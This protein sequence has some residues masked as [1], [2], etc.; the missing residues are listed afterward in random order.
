MK[1]KIFNVTLI[2]TFI[3]VVAISTLVGIA[4]ANVPVY[5]ENLPTL[6]DNKK[7][8]V[9]DIALSQVDTLEDSETHYTIYAEWYDSEN[10][11][12][13]NWSNIFIQY[14]LHY[15]E[16][17]YLPNDIILEDFINNVD[18]IYYKDTTYTPTEGDLVYL[19]INNDNDVDY[20][21]ILVDSDE[22]GLID[23]VVIGDYNDKVSLIE[24][25]YSLKIENT[26][27]NTFTILGYVNI[28]EELSILSTENNE[29][30]NNDNNEEL[31]DNSNEEENND[32]SNEDDSLLLGAN[33][34]GELT[35]TSNGYTITI[36]YNNG[37]IPD[38]TEL[39]FEIINSLTYSDLL[40]AYI[41]TNNQLIN[42]VII[43][44]YDKDKNVITP[45]EDVE[46]TITW[47]SSYGEY[48]KLI[49]YVTDNSNMT[50]EE[51]ELD[52]LTTTSLTYTTSDLGYIAIYSDEEIAQTPVLSFSYIKKGPNTDT[53]ATD[54]QVLI[55]KIINL[56]S[57]TFQK[58]KVEVGP[59]GYD[60]SGNQIFNF[61]D[62]TNKKA[63]TDYSKC[64]TSSGNCDQLLF[65][66]PSPKTTKSGVVTTYGGDGNYIGKLY[67]N[68]VTTIHGRSV[69]AVITIDK[70]VY[71]STA[72]TSKKDVSFMRFSVGNSK[73]IV[74][75]CVNN[76]Y[77]LTE[78][79][80][81]TSNTPIIQV[82]LTTTFYWS[83]TNYT[84][85]V[86]EKFMGIAY[87]IDQSD[88]KEALTF[89]KNYTGKFYQFYKN[90][91]SS[92][93]DLYT[94]T[95]SGGIMFTPRKDNLDNDDSWIIG[96]IAGIVYNGYT[97][98]FR[99]ADCQT[100][101]YAGYADNNNEPT[102]SITDLE[103][104]TN[105]YIAGEELTYNID[106]SVGTFFDD[107]WITYSKYE[108][109]DYLPD[110]VEF[111]DARI[112]INN[113]EV[114]NLTDKLTND[115][116]T[117]SYDSSKHKLTFTF[118][119]D[120]LSKMSSYNNQSIE[121]QID[122]KIN[123]NSVGDRI[124]NTGIVLINNSTYV[125]NKVS[126]MTAGYALPETGGTNQ[127]ISILMGLIFILGS[128]VGG[129]IYKFKYQG[130]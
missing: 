110:E 67:F 116:G 50:V 41:G 62:L 40:S 15:A 63:G 101:Y 68:G 69:D 28:P 60:S 123:D 78:T 120:Y 104:H 90:G 3:F 126:I 16:I 54:P 37:A 112:Y 98:T 70:V 27:T 65:T 66:L 72:A 85:P 87:D 130:E 105:L 6:T 108:Y 91:V 109:I 84:S 38:G 58:D 80:N 14:V 86:N 129:Y 35:K 1:N 102:K 20:I 49:K 59:G 97:L 47:D 125:T 31:D 32:N 79:Y 75:H 118:K 121:M 52:E 93:K 76:K 71:K 43:Q 34:Q 9:I 10:T 82:T 2:F 53:N 83:D 55:N 51:I 96:G 18:S 21:G 111:I 11:N 94:K 89:E 7:Q 113:V 48:E 33:L 24:D 107:Q 13:E 127:L 88:E 117:L 25:F 61:V 77:G 114:A 122:V 23:D 19:D 8:N 128:F 22:D 42:S 99:G 57:S 124:D 45:T 29:E 103:T 44:F 119:S 92:Y 56:N 81:I 36:T 64:S 26:D 12:I 95:S 73:I 39:D 30:E 4:E 17:D 106:M 46:V 100:S 74:G 115:Y 5:E